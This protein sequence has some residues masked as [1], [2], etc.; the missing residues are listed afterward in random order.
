MRFIKRLKKMSSL[1]R[2]EILDWKDIN[3]SVQS[4]IGHTKHADTYGLRRSIFERVIF[5]R[6]VDSLE[7]VEVGDNKLLLLSKREGVSIETIANL[8]IQEK[9]QETGKEGK[10]V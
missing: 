10:N 2:K 9:L 6:A 8:W 3:P 7:I 5:C 1:Y 4:W